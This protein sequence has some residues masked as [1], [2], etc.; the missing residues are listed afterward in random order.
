[1]SGRPV[2]LD[3]HRTTDADG[4]VHLAIEVEGR[5]VPLGGTVIAV[6]RNY[7]EH[8]SEQHVDPPERPLLFAKLSSSLAADGDEIVWDPTVATQVDYEAELGVVIGRVASRVTVAEALG[9]VLGYCNIND[10]TARDLQR[11]DSQWL[12]G[13]S[14]DTFCPLGPVVVTADEVGDP[15]DLRVTCTVNGEVRQSAST[16]EMIFSVAEVISFISQVV[17]LRPGDVICTGTPGGVGMH[18]TPPQLLADGDEVVVEI[19]GLGRLVNR[20]RTTD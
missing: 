16:S 9:Y 19:E 8:A 13:K 12:R 17:T 4:G 3:V 20:C 6:G 1:M 18:R 7:H 2:R 15:Q 11:S 10:V 5:V 14:H